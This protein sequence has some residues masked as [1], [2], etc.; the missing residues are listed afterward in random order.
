MEKQRPGR[1]PHPAPEGF[2][3]RV[4]EARLKAKLEVEDCVEMMRRE[5]PTFSVD[6]WRGW[7]RDEPSRDPPFT[8]AMTACRILKVDPLWLATGESK[9]PKKKLP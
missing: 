8:V 4:R 7:E 9:P 2:P 3:A 1:P 5:H 6:T